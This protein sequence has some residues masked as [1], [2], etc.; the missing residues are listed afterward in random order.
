MVAV[1]DTPF[2]VPLGCSHGQVPLIGKIPV[3]LLDLNQATDD[4]DLPES[5]G[6]IHQDY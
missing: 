4:P 1:G 2:R 5:A 6:T 3:D